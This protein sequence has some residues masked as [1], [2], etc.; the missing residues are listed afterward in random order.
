[1]GSENGMLRFV[2]FCLTWS[3]HYRCVHFLSVTLGHRCSSALGISYWPE[4]YGF[5]GAVIELDLL[6][7][8][9]QYDFHEKKWHAPWS[10][11]TAEK[12]VPF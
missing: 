8:H 2:L 3:D 7:F 1:M 4:L 6:F 5:G 11:Q 12:G 10:G 9:W